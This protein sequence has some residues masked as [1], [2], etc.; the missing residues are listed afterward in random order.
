M[1]EMAVPKNEA[2]RLSTERMLQ[3]VS[4]LKRERDQIDQAIAALEGLATGWPGRTQRVSKNKKEPKM[5]LFEKAKHLASEAAD[6]LGDVAEG[7]KHAA[8]HAGEAVMD[9]AAH[10]GDALKDAGSSAIHSD[11]AKAAADKLGD[12]K[13]AVAGA[14]ASIADKVKDKIS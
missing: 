8:Q 13:D 1:G 12:A 11:L 6:K 7:A 5:D 14:G 10:A 2:S 3:F 9:K 4:Q